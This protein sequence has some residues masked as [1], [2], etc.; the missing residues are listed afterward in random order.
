MECI[1][2]GVRLDDAREWLTHAQRLAVGASSHHEQLH[3]AAQL[4]RLDQLQGA[5][6]TARENLQHLLPAFR[7]I[8]DHRCAARC[9]LWLGELEHERSA[10]EQAEHL[11]TESVAIATGIHETAIAEAGLRRLAQLATQ[12]GRDHE[13]ARLLRQVDEI[14]GLK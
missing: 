7:R 14:A 5:G 11:L 2:L 6:H 1:D 4:A 13:A 10:T 12:R 8:G 3:V 9:L